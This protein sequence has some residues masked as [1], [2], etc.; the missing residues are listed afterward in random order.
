MVS[1]RAVY[2]RAQQAGLAHEDLA[3]LT[4]LYER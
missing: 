4:T 2:Q 3:A 1:T